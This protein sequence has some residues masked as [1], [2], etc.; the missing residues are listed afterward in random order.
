MAGVRS[1]AGHGFAAR[2]PPVSTGD[3]RALAEVLATGLPTAHI[4][5]GTDGAAA[6]RGTSEPLAPPCAGAQGM[7]W[8][9]IGELSCSR[10]APPASC[11]GQ[12][13]AVLAEGS[14][15]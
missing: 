9:R 14:M 6:T 4:A 2:H 12:S 7:G 8:T 1:R 11:E 10:P 13:R 3:M 5:N 15:I